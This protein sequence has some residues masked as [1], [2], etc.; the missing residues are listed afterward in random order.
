MRNIAVHSKMHV[1]LNRQIC[2]N[3]L[4][5]FNRKIFINGTKKNGDSVSN[6]R[7]NIASFVV[8]YM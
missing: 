5:V 2:S 3:F 1:R 8:T 6:G 4:D 7:L